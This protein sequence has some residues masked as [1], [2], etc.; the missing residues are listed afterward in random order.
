MEVGKARKRREI[1]KELENYYSMNSPISL[2]VDHLQR[3]HPGQGRQRAVARNHQRIG[4]EAVR[5]G[6]IVGDDEHLRGGIMQR[7]TKESK[8][9]AKSTKRRTT[10]KTCIFLHLHS[11]KS[12]QKCT[13]AIHHL[14]AASLHFF[15]AAAH[16]SAELVVQDQENDGGG[17]VLAVG[18]FNEGKRA[19]LQCSPTVT[20]GVEVGALLWVVKQRRRTKAREKGKTTKTMIMVM[21]SGG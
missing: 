13:R 7:N 14:G 5:E 6:R 11:T 2:N 1:S 17:A 4:V 21:A 8:N 10:E 19:V 15:G 9:E 18:P 3:Q 12:S 20:L 16:L